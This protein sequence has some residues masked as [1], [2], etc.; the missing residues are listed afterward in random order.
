MNFFPS[1][2]LGYI[3]SLSEPRTLQDIAQYWYNL[4]NF[5]YPFFKLLKYLTDQV[6]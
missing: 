4:T 2:W 1:Y 3:S 6:K 5:N